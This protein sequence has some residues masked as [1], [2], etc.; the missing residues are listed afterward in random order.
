M[1]NP[2]YSSTNQELFEKHF[3][4]QII[5]AT[6][7]ITDGFH[8]EGKPSHATDKST[9]FAVN[10]DEWD[11]KEDT[12]KS[13]KNALIRTGSLSAAALYKP[14]DTYCSF[15]CTSI[16]GALSVIL[17]FLVVLFGALILIT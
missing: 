14:Q 15:V 7:K 12:D 6:M 11:K 16:G 3:C 8:C 1:F 13:M 10:K 9:L 5:V 17:Y 2:L 4:N